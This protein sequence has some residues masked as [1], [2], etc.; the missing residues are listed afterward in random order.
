MKISCL[1]FHNS[2][3]IWFLFL[4]YFDF[5]WENPFKHG[6]ISI[7]CSRRVRRGVFSFPYRIIS[8][9][10][11]FF[12]KRRCFSSLFHLR[13]VYPERYLIC[14]F[15]AHSM[16]L[17]VGKD[18]V[19]TYIFSAIN[20]SYQLEISDSSGSHKEYYLFNLSAGDWDLW[21]GPAKG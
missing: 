9:S 14:Y 21:N 2:L 3:F 13:L 15:I 19:N 10:H 20:L 16:D 12:M 4:I 6:C 17:T 1:L 11:T 7:L 8:F 5:A 18:V